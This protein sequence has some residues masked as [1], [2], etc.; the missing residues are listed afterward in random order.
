[1][2]EDD[3]ETFARMLAV[4]SPQERSAILRRLRA[5]Q[6]VGRRLRG[7]R[8][9]PMREVG[10]VLYDAFGLPVAVI[11]QVHLSLVHDS[12][13]LRPWQLGE[14]QI[15]MQCDGITNEEFVDEIIRRE[16]NGR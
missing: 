2:T 14:R 13:M 4:L 8:P 9:D 11:K 1:M 5:I 16:A 12:R 3:V 7:Q 15:D 10:S 6:V